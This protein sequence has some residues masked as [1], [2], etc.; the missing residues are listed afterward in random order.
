VLLIVRPEGIAGFYAARRLLQ[1]YDRPY[2][3]ELIPSDEPLT[4]GLL[5]DGAATVCQTAIERMLKQRGDVPDSV[6]SSPFREIDRPQRQPKE[7]IPHSGPAANS[8]GH[9]PGRYEFRRTARGMELVRVDDPAGSLDPR[10]DPTANSYEDLHYI[11]NIIKE[12]LYMWTGLQK[13]Q[14][15][16]KA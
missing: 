8:P 7:F 10:N 13:C 16:E 3:Y 15:R 1:S 9:K 12:R 14:N 4:F 5:D 2:G 6:A 11:C